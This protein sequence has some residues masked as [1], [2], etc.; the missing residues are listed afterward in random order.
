MNAIDQKSKDFF[1]G[2]LRAKGWTEIKDTTTYCYYDIAATSPT[3]KLWRFELKQRN[4]PSTRFN[5]TIMEMSKLNA[6]L[7]EKDQY[8]N[9]AL[10]TFFTD[11]WTLSNILSPAYADTIEAAHTTSFQDQTIW[12]KE[13][14]HYN[15]DQTFNYEKDQSI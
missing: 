8:D 6:F 4:M 5:D 10:V 7:K 14:I 1:V 2:I 9:A 12:T 3:G 13:V 15:F 11:R